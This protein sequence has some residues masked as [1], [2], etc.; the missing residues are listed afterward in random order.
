MQLIHTPAEGE[1][2]RLL[3]DEVE[4]ADS[5]LAQARGLMFRRS[6][7][8]GYALEF[9]FE[10]AK[11]R[12]LHMACVPFAIDAL[13]LVDGEVRANERLRPWVGLGRAEA[14]TVVELPAGAAAG[15]RKGD[16]VERREGE[17]AVERSPLP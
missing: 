11:A 4:T 10:G 5:F 3:A 15:V 6:V 13:W 7:P 17:R 2:E 9:P 14:D 1:A 8:D 16:R 12:S